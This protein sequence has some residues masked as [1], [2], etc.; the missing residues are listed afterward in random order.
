MKVNS[1]PSILRSSRDEYRT[2][3]SVCI[4]QIDP[5][6]FI[7]KCDMDSYNPMQFYEKCKQ[8][9]MTDNMKNFIMTIL[10]K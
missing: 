1:Y 8:H 10:I 9:C 7:R 2:G 4:P 5:Q 6:Y 3:E